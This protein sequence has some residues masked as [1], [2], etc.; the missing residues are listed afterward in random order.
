MAH[1]RSRQSTRDAVQPA[2]YSV[3]VAASQ[4]RLLALTVLCPDRG[5]LSLG[6]PRPPR[7]ALGTPVTHLGRSKVARRCNSMGLSRVVLLRVSSVMQSRHQCD[8]TTPSATALARLRVLTEYPWRVASS[9]M[10]YR[11]PSYSLDILR[12]MLKLCSAFR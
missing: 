7:R 2:N 10:F 9:E 8:L 4:K 6:G 12:S 3:W 1:R 5:P 11:T